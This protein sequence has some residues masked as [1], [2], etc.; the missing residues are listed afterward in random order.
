MFYLQRAI[1]SRIWIILLIIMS[2][3]LP[4]KCSDF[5][6]SSDSWIDRFFSKRLKHTY[7]YNATTAPAIAQNVM[8]FGGK[9]S[10][11]I[12]LFS[13]VVFAVEVETERERWRFKLPP[14]DAI[15]HTPVIDDGMLYVGTYGSSPHVYALDVQTGQL[16]WQTKAS[17]NVLSPVVVFD[18]VACFRSLDGYLYA[19]DANTGNS[20]WSFPA[21]GTLPPLKI[22]TRFEGRPDEVVS[23][24]T[25]A[26]GVVYIG[27]RS[28]LYALDVQTGKPLWRFAT[29]N[30]VDSTP[31]VQKGRV[32]IGSGD[33]TRHRGYIYGLDAQTG[34]LQWQYSV[35]EGMVDSDLAIS[36]N[37]IYFGGVS[38]NL[39]AV[40]L[41]TR[42]EK[43]RFPTK[44]STSYTGAF[45][46][47][48]TVFFVREEV[49]YAFDPQTGN[50]YW[51]YKECH[52]CERRSPSIEGP[53]LYND[54]LYYVLRNRIYAFDATPH[55]VE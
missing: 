33:A 42:Q 4:V 15:G 46:H 52:N 36:D 21:Y 54:T 2:L 30:A 1:H 41:V 34:K 53:S 14:A 26:N 55:A 32:Y 11:D 47:K 18:G 28:G 22:N 5:R 6:I 23:F 49:L 44:A 40:D 25:V 51:E 50:P 10:F 13:S 17:G 35:H 27:T 39:H 38:P 3:L 43:W 48:G 16:K 45:A 19:L 24:P 20:K 8:Y 7:K 12:S 29:D 9:E 37:V 31:L